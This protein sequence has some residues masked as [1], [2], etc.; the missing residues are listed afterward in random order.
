LR[1]INQRYLKAA[2]LFDASHQN[3]AL[4]QIDKILEEEPS[5]PFATMLKRLGKV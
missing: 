5:Y 2:G 3:E 4:Q 1:K